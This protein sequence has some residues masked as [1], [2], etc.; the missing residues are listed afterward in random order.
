MLYVPRRFDVRCPRS[1][2]PPPPSCVYRPH[3]LRCTRVVSIH[4]A[5]V[6]LASHIFLSFNIMLTLYRPKRR[7]RSELLTTVTDES[8]TNDLREERRHHTQHIGRG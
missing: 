2:Y 6:L 1:T 7:N 4:Q 8:A 5:C 3:A